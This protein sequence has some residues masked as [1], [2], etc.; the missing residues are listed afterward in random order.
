MCKAVKGADPE[1]IDRNIQQ[2]LNSAAHLGRGFIGKGNREQALRTDALDFD[3]PGS[4]VNKH[5][6]FAAPGTGDNQR[7]PGGRSNGLP[8]CVVQRIKYRCNVHSRTRL[9]GERAI[10]SDMNERRVCRPK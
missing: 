2:R 3:Q 8:L 1:L 5:P 10:L 7:R 9:L 6:G 4:P